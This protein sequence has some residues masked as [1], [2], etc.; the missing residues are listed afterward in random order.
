MISGL[1]HILDG[2]NRCHI[3]VAKDLFDGR[4][5]VFRSCFRYLIHGKIITMSMVTFFDKRQKGNPIKYE[6]VLL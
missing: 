1:I 2:H 3:G 4:I 5:Y 6:A